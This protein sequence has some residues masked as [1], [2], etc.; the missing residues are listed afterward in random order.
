MKVAFIGKSHEFSL[1][2]LRAISN[3]HQLTALI[4]SAPRS[5]QP[6]KPNSKIKSHLS[7]LRALLSQNDSLQEI[8]RLKKVPYFYLERGN[9]SDMA[10]F[11]ENVSPDII[12]VASLS[13]LL[14][15]QVLDTAKHGAI[16]LHPS[17]LPRYHGP[18]PWFWQYYNFEKEW[19][20]TVHLIDEGQ[21]TGPIIKQ[22]AFTLPTGTDI[23]DATR[24]VSAIGAKLMLEA[25]NEIESGVV[26]MKSQP[27]HDCPKARLVQRNEKL[28][29]WNGWDLE[30]VWH[31]LRGTYPWLDAVE[32]PRKVRWWKTWEIGQIE[33]GHCA[34]TPGKVYQDNKGYYIAHRQGKIRLDIKSSGMPKCWP[35]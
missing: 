10:R 12:C 16:N 22:E 30:R 4:E 13:Q 15:K 33:K 31:F 1:T 7:R 9:Q 34:R 21:D 19:G 5:G 11:L 32:Y 6:S 24:M 17:L 18:F 20:V 3:H 35:G 23:V 2:P 25:L 14:G 27:R 26:A 8:A 28:V 29:D